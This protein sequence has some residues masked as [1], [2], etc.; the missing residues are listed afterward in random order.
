MV[1][2]QKIQQK[3]E[4]VEKG[5]LEDKKSQ[6]LCKRLVVQL[7]NN[8]EP[9]EIKRQFLKI[10]EQTLHGTNY[11]PRAFKIVSMGA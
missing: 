7:D 6:D 1:P 5:L 10:M 9:Q 2:Y 3:C 8:T 11:D 4:E